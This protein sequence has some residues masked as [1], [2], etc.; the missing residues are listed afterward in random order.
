MGCS[1]YCNTSG[2]RKHVKSPVASVLHDPHDMGKTGA[3]SASTASVA[4]FVVVI[5]EKSKF[6]A[7]SAVF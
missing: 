5:V 2:T 1:Y 7:K 6:P 3:G 4:G